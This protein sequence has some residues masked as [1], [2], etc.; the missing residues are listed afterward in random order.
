MLVTTWNTTKAARLTI[1]AGASMLFL[2]NCTSPQT[3]SPP[4]AEASALARELCIAWAKSQ[5][6]WADG[7]SENTINS[8]DYAYRV[9]EAACSPITGPQIN[10]TE[11]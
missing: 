8:V 10:A 4:P 11:R 2:V 5:P 3:A 1:F 9:Q 7:D 6:T